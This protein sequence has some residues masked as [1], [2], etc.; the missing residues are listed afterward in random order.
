MIALAAIYDYKLVSG[1]LNEISIGA[2]I[3]LKMESSITIRSHL[4]LIG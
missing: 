3:L 4:T 1:G 2:M